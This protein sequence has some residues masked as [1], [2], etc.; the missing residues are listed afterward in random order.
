MSF[1]YN[2]VTLV[3]R[4]A[5]NPESRLV[6]DVHQKTFFL[7]AVDRAYKKDNQ[8]DTDFIPVI[9]WGKQAKLVLSLLKKGVPVLVWGRIQIFNF[10]KDNEKKRITEI[11]GEN[12]QILQTK[13]KVQKKK[14]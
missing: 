3:G 2:Q 7:L 4:L 5:S 9:F 13:N 1:N 11:I 10:E 8:V 6:N 12:F 14:N